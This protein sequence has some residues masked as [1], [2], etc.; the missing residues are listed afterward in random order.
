MPTGIPVAT[1]AIGNAKNAGL[2]A[3]QIL[4]THQPELL[5]KVQ[6]YR[7]SL[8]DIVKAKQ[9]KLEQLGYKQYLD[10]K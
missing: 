5:E 4:A 9:S 6:A 1:V 2:L 10:Q 3:I 8:S 7:Q